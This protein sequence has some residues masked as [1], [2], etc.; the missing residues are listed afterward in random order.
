[1]N[2]KTLP[3]TGLQAM[4]LCCASHKQV[5]MRKI[6]FSSIIVF[7]LTMF[8]GC[9]STNTVS[10]IPTKTA[11]IAPGP[12]PTV[13]HAVYFLAG[14]EE[15]SQVWRYRIDDLS[16]LQI[17]H[18]KTKVDEFAVSPITGAIAFI[19]DNQLFIMD[20]DGE[21]R[22]RIADGNTVDVNVEDYP[23]RSQI[24]S[25]VFSP[26]GRNLAYGFDGLHLYNLITGE[27]THVLTNLGNLLGEPF[28]FSKEVYV[29]G[30]WSPDG[31]LLLIIMGYY[32]GS[33]LAVMDLNAEQPFRRLWSDGPLCCLFNWSPDGNSVLVSNPYYTG[34]IPGLWRFSAET[35]EQRVVVSGLLEDG[36]SNFVGWPIQL[37]SGELLFFY[38]NEHF[39]P[40][41][42]IPLTMVRS[43]PDGTHLEKVRPEKFHIIDVLWVQDGSAVLILQPSG[44]DKMQI[45][46]AKTDGSPLQILFEGQ[47]IRN[48]AWGF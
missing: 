26:D 16:A 42:G 25:P 5:K 11:T 32:E 29:P 33:T 34:D 36:S 38:V 37:D 31:S 47:G 4:V 44:N 7:I 30:S 17:T 1:M 48:L 9:N 22:L 28:V 39:S 6:I 18:E 19:S 41:I 46:V 12:T 14:V 35:G 8:S 27:D 45:I 10:P 23:F 15:E 24:S 43:N 40:D 20:G 13:L 2:Q 21:N 3:D